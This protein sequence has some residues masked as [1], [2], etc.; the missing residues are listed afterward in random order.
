MTLNLPDIALSIYRL[1]M[2]AALSQLLKSVS[3]KSSPDHT[4]GEELELL[5]HYF[6]IQK[7]RYGGGLSMNCQVED[8]TLYSA[9]ILKFIFQI[10][11][12]NAIFHGIEPSGARGLIDL[13]IRYINDQ[14]DISVSVTD[15]GVGMTQEEIRQVM[16]SA[17]SSSDLFRK[18]GIHNIQKRIQYAYGPSYGISIRSVP[19]QFTTVVVTIPHVSKEEPDCV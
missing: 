19:G 13:E 11:V 9:M 1:Q 15:N 12:E 6:L 18:I 7:Y 16:E 2:A 3:K 10:I 4:I 17:P 14:K 5:N 8:E